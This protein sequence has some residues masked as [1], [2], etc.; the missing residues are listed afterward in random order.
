[1]ALL[2]KPHSF[3]ALPLLSCRLSLCWRLGWRAAQGWRPT[4]AP[5]IASSPPCSPALAFGGLDSGAGCILGEAGLLPG[6][7]T[8]SPRQDTP[9]SHSTFHLVGSHLVGTQALV[10]GFSPAGVVPLPLPS[11]QLALRPP[12]QSPIWTAVAH[13]LTLK[14][15]L[16]V[17]RMIF[18]MVALVRLVR[19]GQS[20]PHDCRQ[21]WDPRRVQRRLQDTSSSLR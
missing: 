13:H 10:V 15:T 14:H 19:P 11:T 1:M 7:G 9:E 18:W 20:P 8:G 6:G 16:E 17:V 2:S 4:P 5:P 3:A 21:L 12:L